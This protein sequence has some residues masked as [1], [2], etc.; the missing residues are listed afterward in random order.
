MIAGGIITN[1]LGKEI[2]ENYDTFI[3]NE[4]EMKV[5]KVS[6]K[7]E[8]YSEGGAVMIVPGKV[9]WISGISHDVHLYD[10]TTES[11][12]AIHRF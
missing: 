1:Y 6:M 4:A 7:F 8:D 11:I 12:E 2:E 10:N 5:R 9:M 3:L